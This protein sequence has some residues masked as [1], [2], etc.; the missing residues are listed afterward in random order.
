MLI[1]FSELI[2]KYNIN[3]TGILHVGA[4][5]GQEAE[6]YYKNGIK[7]TVWIEADEAVYGQLKEHLKLYPNAIAINACATYIDDFPVSFHITDNNSESSSI[8]EMGTHATVHPNVKV[9]N[10][11][12]LQS[13]TIETLFKEHKLN[14]A[15]Y[16]MIN[17]DIQGAELLALK[18]MRKMLEKVNF[19]YLEVNNDHLYRGG[20]LI[21]DI[22]DYLERFNIVRVETKWS[23]DTG[24]GDAFYINRAWMEKNKVILQ[25]GVQTN[26]ISRLTRNPAGNIAVP[27]PAA[28]IA[29]SHEAPKPQA[30][31]LSLTHLIEKFEMKVT[32]IINIGSHLGDEINEYRRLGITKFVMIEPNPIAFRRM[33]EK[34]RVGETFLNLA[35]SDL[36]GNLNMYVSSGNDGAANSF[37]KPTKTFLKQFPGIAWDNFGHQQVAVSRLDSLGLDVGLYNMISIDTNGTEKLALSGGLTTLGFM[38]YIYAKVYFTDV[39]EGCT[40]VEDLDAFLAGHN[41]IRVE[42]DK[43]GVTFGTALYAKR[44]YVKLPEEKKQHTIEPVDISNEYLELKDVKNDFVVQVPDKFRPHQL[45]EKP[46]D[47]IIPFEEWFY[48]N[49]GFEDQ[50][51]DVVY[52]PIF[53]NSFYTNEA[54]KQPEIAIREMQ[55]YLKGLDKSKKYYTINT[56]DLGLLNDL[57]GLDVVLFSTSEGKYVTHVIPAACTPHKFQFK[58]VKKDIFLSFVGNITDP[59]RQEMI[60][61]LPK[62]NP[63][64]YISTKAHT[65]EEYCKVLARSKYVLC[66]KG[67]GTSASFRASEAL[68]Y[69]AIPVYYKSKAFNGV[70]LGPE[71]KNIYDR[72]NKFEKSYGGIQV[73]ATGDANAVTELFALGQYKSHNTF[74]SVKR[75]ILL[76]LKQ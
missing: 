1:Q 63:D 16:D 28:S 49:F 37:L 20:A 48:K 19:A 47:N 59:C 35:C 43:A 31:H 22:D 12:T 34:Y 15:D 2:K 68:Q 4:N 71:I 23:G 13:S 21:K 14:I 64:Y 39:Y 50:L 55:A 11:V 67:R 60:D 40:K 38:H 70:D 30:G 8:L 72:L 25:P 52:L 24:W 53:W 29:K 75:E 66:P 33:D 36:N 45:Y 41:F 69:G 9:T 61:F 62:G 6:E 58:G 65:L 32:G 56:Y 54:S 3:P 76:A 57:E 26:G 73:E 74:E 5:T 18:G 10:T 7:R 51:P 17:I 27:V 46:E 44:Q 42:T